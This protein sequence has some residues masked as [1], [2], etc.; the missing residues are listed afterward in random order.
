MELN[1]STNFTLTSTTQSSSSLKTETTTVI[2]NER[3]FLHTVACQAIAGAF[4]WAAILITGYHV[5]LSVCFCFSSSY[6]YV[7]R[8][9][10][11][12]FTT[13]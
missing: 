3:L 7:Y 10:L 4:T 13:L 11:F 1:Y 6:E 8:L 12:S 2:Y 9:D 5:R